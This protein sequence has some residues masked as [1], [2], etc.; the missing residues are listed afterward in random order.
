[1]NFL[2]QTILCGAAIVVAG[3]IVALIIAIVRK[4]KKAIKS[5]SIFIV[6]TVIVVVILYFPLSNLTNNGEQFLPK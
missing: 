5:L 6:I 3:A 2:Y 1:M 4:D